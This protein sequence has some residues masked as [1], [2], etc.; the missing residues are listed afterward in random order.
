MTRRGRDLCL[1]SAC[2]AVFAMIGGCNGSGDE[3]N[4]PPL[5]NGP[6]ADGG[7]LPAGGPAPGPGGPSG[8]GASNPEIRTIMVKLNKGP[9]ALGMQIG[10]SLKAE[11]PAWDTIQPQAKE[12]A[13]LA[14]DLVK[15]EPAKGSKDSWSKLSAKYAE[16]A[17]ELDKA[18]QAKDKDAAT[19]AH[20]DLSASCMACHRQHRGG[21]GGGMGPGMMGR[22]G[23]G[24]P[25]G[26]G[27]GR[28]PGGPGGPPPGGPDGPP[29]GGPPPD[30]P[31]P[32]RPE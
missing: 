13:Q 32:D 26:P 31:P 8:K 12:Y 14:G 11:K 10:Q 22:P 15:H 9:S 21:P 30:G 6:A 3:A 29:P 18:A 1:L 17:T 5:V 2:M 27:G 23:G 20:E 25:G 28:P 24:R 19:A 4:G 7:G 16:L